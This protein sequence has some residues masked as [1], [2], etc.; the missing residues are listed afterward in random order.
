MTAI[1]DL[2]RIRHVRDAGTETRIYDGELWMM[3]IRQH[4]SSHSCR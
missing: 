2:T 1:D 3:L 4:R